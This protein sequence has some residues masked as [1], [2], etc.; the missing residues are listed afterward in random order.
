MRRSSYWYIRLL[1]AHEA[2][3]W[4]V[5]L[6]TGAALL[7][8]FGIWVAI[9]VWLGNDVHF[10][11][12]SLGIEVGII[13]VASYSVGVTVSTIHMTPRDVLG[14]APALALDEKSLACKAAAITEQNNAIHLWTLCWILTTIVLTW[15]TSGMAISDSAL[16]DELSQSTI[17]GW[18]YV[19]NL[20]F[21]FTLSQLVWIDIVLARRLGK[22]LEEHGRINLLD[23]SDLQTLAKRMR[24]SVLVWIP[25]VIYSTP[26]LFVLLAVVILP[27]IGIRR[28]YIEE[29]SRQL[30]KVRA[31]IAD[32]S[33]AVV[34]GSFTSES[35][36]L[37]E[38]V[39]WEQRLQQTK[40]WPYQLTVYS[41]VFLYAGIGLSSWVG[42][43]LVERLIGALFG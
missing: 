3:P 34:D 12:V 17:A 11:V 16:A 36:N 43:A 40:V 14:L 1:T 26:N 23:R 18:P 10:S 7:L 42:A 9:F 15:W 6:V 35:S 32:R 22:L 27:A 19:R 28:R 29:K 25:L 37:T 13:A 8:A 5:G 4:F 30:E 20:F 31:R 21:V 2:R 24:R 41:R 39:A 38:L 33:A